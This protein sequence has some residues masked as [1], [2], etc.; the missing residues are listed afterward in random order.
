MA[1]LDKNELLGNPLESTQLQPQSIKQYDN[2]YIVCFIVALNMWFD[3]RGF[4]CI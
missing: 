3:H 4:E 2:Y 1:Y